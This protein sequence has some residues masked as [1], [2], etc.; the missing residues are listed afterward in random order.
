MDLQSKPPWLTLAEAAALLNLRQ[1][2]LASM[3][4][5][6]AGPSFRRHGGSIF[7]HY[8]DFKARFDH[9]RWDATVG[10]PK[11]SLGPLLFMLTGVALVATACLPKHPQLIWNASP[12]VPTG[13]YRVTPGIPGL[14]ELALVQPTWPMAVWAGRRGYLRRGAYLLKPVAA[15][16]GDRVCRFGTRVFVRGRRVALALAKDSI[17]RQMPRWH[18][19]HTLGPEEVFVLAAHRASVDSRYFGIVPTKYLAGRAMPLWSR[20]QSN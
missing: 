19:C 12:S 20:G 10:R 4:W 11:G 7:N 17:G 9:G 6:G 8:D 2:T 16:A 18:G 14:G 1:R 15:I 3:R 13:L 5:H